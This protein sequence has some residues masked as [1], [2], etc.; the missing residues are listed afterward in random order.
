MFLRWLLG[1]YCTVAIAGFAAAP[2]LF[3]RAEDA[4]PVIIGFF[5]LLFSLPFVLAG[6][7]I[8]WGLQKGFDRILPDSRWRA[9]LVTLLTM[10]AGA[11]GMYLFTR[12]PFYAVMAACAALAGGA[13]AQWEAAW[14]RGWLVVILTA[15]LS[16]GGSVAAHQVWPPEPAA[17]ALEQ[18]VMPG[19]AELD[20]YRPGT[21]TI[22]YE[23]ESVVNG[24]VYHRHVTPPLIHVQVT[25]LVTGAD[26]PVTAVPMTDTY[27]LGEREGA[28]WFAFAIERPGR[29]RIA[30]RYP[31][32]TQMP[33]V[34]MA[35]T[36][37][38]R[39]SR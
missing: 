36:R 7:L 32:R 30:A 37:E 26:I 24:I 5:F 9:W 1:A 33:K 27:I 29:Y 17:P 35:V 18:L 12:T 3:P 19:A 11:T 34:V 22:Y 8:G 2:F 39:A 28:S 15:V 31:T 23:H 6:A 21:Y 25:E 13:L 4:T 38:P 14:R 20:L 16:T 10:A